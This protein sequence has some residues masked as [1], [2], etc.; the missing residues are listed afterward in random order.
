M[1]TIDK[2]EEYYDYVVIGSGFGGS[3]SA[4]RLAE[5]GY[6]VLVV[7][8][9]KSFE[10]EDFPVSN[11]R[12][13]KWLWLPSVRFFGFFKMTFFRHVGILS[14][15]G[16]GGGSL[17]YANT[18]AR[19]EKKFFSSGSWAGL[20]DWNEEL[21]PYYDLA[22][23]MLGADENPKLFDSDLALEELAKRN[24]ISE[25]FSRTRV[26]VFFGEPE[27]VV[28]DPYF[29]GDGPDREGC[30][31]CGGCMTGC[32]HNAK[33]TLDR[34]YLYL[35]EKKGAQ[36]LAR[37]RVIA[38]TPEGKLDGSEGYLV[39][40]RKSTSILYSP[41][42]SVNCSGV[43]F[44]GGVLGTVRLLLNMKKK[45][46]PG[47]SEMT[48]YEIRTNNESLVLVDTPD[49]SKDFSK[50]V[51]IGS[52][53][54]TDEHS[55]LEPV[56]YASGSGFWKTLGVPLT[57]GR[58][59]V[60]RCGKL[61]KSL[62]TKPGSWLHIYFTR[63]FA[64]QSVIL[65]YMQHLNSTLR[66]AKGPVFLKSTLSD[67]SAPTAFMPESK[68]LANEMSSILGGKPFV[69]VTEAV[70]GIPTTAHILGGAVIGKDIS[71]GV[72]DADHKVFGYENMYI[73]DGSAVS[74]N[75]GVNPS[76]TISAM[77]ERAMSKIAVKLK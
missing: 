61:V 77:T 21:L 57:H 16:V 38:V 19:P 26:G 28:P 50:G 73:C 17:V 53:L 14:G 54:Q 74:A 27:K 44:A 58:N 40:Y 25:K 55:H 35:A 64:R 3:I 11:W 69:L 5:K 60:L 30:S 9:G 22:E 7:E 31:F 67:G 46:L 48:G 12:L 20:R 47:L 39:T 15:V 29:G 56:R 59:A 70:A 76:L 32:R 43:I 62:V 71:T 68:T 51:A 23:K 2:A 36:V 8:K 33:N 45:M 66:L 18:L 63:D 10:K 52:I 72:I 13:R 42:K 41:K 37:H 4:L 1:R 6:S 34:N 65:L 24:G 75:P 49:K